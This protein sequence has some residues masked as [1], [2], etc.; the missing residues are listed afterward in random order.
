VFD[1]IGES[2]AVG[3][4]HKHDDVGNS[5]VLD[6]LAPSFHRAG[7]SISGYLYVCGG[8]CVCETNV[9]EYLQIY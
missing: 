2:I 9:P 4:G 7:L 6:P 3:A 5:V 8:L 1:D